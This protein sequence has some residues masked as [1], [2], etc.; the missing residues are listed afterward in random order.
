MFFTSV[1]QSP[2]SLPA[3]IKCASETCSQIGTAAA[4]YWQRSSRTIILGR[5][6]CLFSFY[7]FESFSSPKYLSQCSCNDWGPITC[8]ISTCGSANFSW[9][10]LTRLRPEMPRSPLECS[11]AQCFSSLRWML[12][13]GR[14]LFPGRFPP[15]FFA[16]LFY[17][18]IAWSS[19]LLSSQA[20]ILLV[21][22]LAG[23]NWHISVEGAEGRASGYRKQAWEQ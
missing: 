15:L 12:F 11:D 8:S 10:Q 7:Y 18:S 5:Y 16:H 21:L 20:V 23:M 2:M 6:I 3:D 17:I 9:E 14:D 13:G 19:K 22:S 1:I 4:Y